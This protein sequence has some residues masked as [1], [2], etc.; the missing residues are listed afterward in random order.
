M[1]LLVDGNCE[2]GFTALW[3]EY[4]WYVVYVTVV[5]AEFLEVKNGMLGLSY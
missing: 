3:R 1:A 5:L 2:N 4:H